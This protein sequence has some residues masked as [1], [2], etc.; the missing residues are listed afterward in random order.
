MVVGSASSWTQYPLWYAHYDGVQ[1]F[2]DSPGILFGGWTQGAIKQYNDHTPNNICAQVDVNYW[3]TP[4]VAAQIPADCFRILK[5]TASVNLRSLPTING[6]IITV[7]PMGSQVYQVGN[8][9]S[10][11]AD[12]YNWDN[13]NYNNQVGFAANSFLVDAGAC[14][15]PTS[16]P[17]P[18][19]V[20]FCV[21]ADPGANLRSSACVQTNNKLITVPNGNV[22]TS[23]NSQLTTNCGYSWRQVSYNDPSSGNTFTG[24]IVNDYIQQCTPLGQYNTNVTLPNLS[25]P[26]KTQV[27]SDSMFL[28]PA[29]IISLLPLLFLFW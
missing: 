28:F 24:F 3:V 12:G 17:M 21:K 10:V 8:G 4:P 20:T 13:I 22:V 11:S 23:V 15:T 27:K 19:S 5:T 1:S 9:A 18:T 26:C 14:P 6:S 29:F 2:A 16:A 7:I 25:G